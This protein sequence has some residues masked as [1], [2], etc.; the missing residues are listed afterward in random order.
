MTNRP[1]KGLLKYDVPI[2]EGNLKKQVPQQKRTRKDANNE[3]QEDEQLTREVLDSML[4]PR[5]F[6]QDGQTLIQF[7]SIAPATRSDVVKLQSQ[8][9]SLLQQRKARNTGI[10]PI[11]SELYAQCF[12][13]IIRQITID[14]SARGKL[15]VRVR[16]ELRMIISDY[17]QLYESAVAWG[18]RKV[19][20]VEQTKDQI[21]EENKTLKEDNRALE[22]N[23]AKLQAKIVELEKASVTTRAEI[24]KNYAEEIAYLKK[25]IAQTKNQ[26]DQIL[27]AK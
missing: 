20:K 11:R 9:D 10:C 27:S 12:D 2:L 15:L 4:P 16:D 25:T 22:A 21:E 18:M 14:C 6:V 3:D 17:Q 24:E 23:V 5:K 19:I 1:G 13:E 26:L 7:V 8:L